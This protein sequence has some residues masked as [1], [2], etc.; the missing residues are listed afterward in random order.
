MQ[1]CGVALFSLQ[2]LKAKTT[3][4]LIQ[5][6]GLAINSDL[7]LKYCQIFLNYV[8]HVCMSRRYIMAVDLS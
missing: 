2:L 4:G 3:H 5:I 6:P 7:I 1:I 8:L